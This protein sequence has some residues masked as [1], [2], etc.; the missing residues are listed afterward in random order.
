MNKIKRLILIDAY[1]TGD[2]VKLDLDGNTNLNGDNGA[3][4]TT[5]LKIVPIFYGAAPGQLVRRTG[6]I[7]SFVNYYLK[8]PFSYIIFEYV[9]EDTTQLV[10]IYRRNQ[11][12]QT[13]SYRFIQS[14][15]QKRLFFGADG[16]ADKAID[17]RDLGAHLKHQ[18]IICSGAMNGEDYK[19]VMQNNTPYSGHS[20]QK[21]QLI[22][23]YRRLYSLC[24]PGTNMHNIDLITTAILGRTPSI[25]GIKAIIKTILINREVISD[26]EIMLQTSAK[27]LQDWA[28]GVESYQ[29]FDQKIHVIKHLQN[30]KTEY[31]ATLQALDQINALAQNTEQTL[32]QDIQQQNALIAADEQSLTQL[33]AAFAHAQDAHTQQTSALTHDH[34]NHQQDADKQIQEKRDWEA[35]DML[36]LQHMVQGLPDLRAEKTA[37]ADSLV[38]LTTGASDIMQQYESLTIQQTARLQDKTQ[39]HRQ[40]LHALES[41]ANKQQSAVSEHFK[42]QRAQAFTEYEHALEQHQAAIKMIW[43]AKAEIQ[44]HLTLCQAPAA[45]QQEADALVTLMTDAHKQRADLDAR[46]HTLAQDMDTQKKALDALAHTYAHKK[47]EQQALDTEQAL[48]HQLTDS[49]GTLL[50]FLRDNCP[51]W[52]ESIGKLLPESLLLRK[53]LHPEWL[54]PEQAS[55]YGIQLDLSGLPCPRALNETQL[56]NALKTLASDITARQTELTQLS[57]QRKPLERTQMALK[58]AQQE[59]QQAQ[60]QHQRAVQQAHTEHQQLQKK[61]ALAIAEQKQ[62]LQTQL[63][64]ICQQVT[65]L[66]A[67]KQQCTRAHQAQMAS[68]NAQEHTEK[69]AIEAQTQIQQTTIHT[70]IQA[71]TEAHT[72]HL[73]TLDEEKHRALAQ[74][75]VDSG[76]VKSL[77]NALIQLDKT[78]TEAEQ[79]EQQVKNYTFWLDGRWAT[80]ALLKRKIDQ[81]SQRLT[82][83]EHTWQASK[84]DH[85]AGLERVRSSLSTHK[86]SQDQHTQAQTQ[87]SGLLQQLTDSELA[88]QPCDVT[89]SSLHTVEWLI[90]AFSQHKDSHRKQQAEGR[91]CYTSVLKIM[92]THLGSAPEQYAVRMEAEISHLPQANEQPWYY[93]AEKLSTYADSGHR[94]DKDQL[95]MYFQGHGRNITDYFAKLKDIDK[96]I[97]RIGNQVTQHIS[98]LSLDIE[99]IGDLAVSITSKLST[100]EYWPY[101]ENFSA[102]YTTWHN[103]NHDTLPNDALIEQLKNIADIIK[104]T[105]LNVSIIQHFDVAIYVTDQGKRTHA[106]TD[107]E[108]KNISSTGL[109]Y[110]IIIMIY[111]AMANMLRGHSDT[112][113]IWP[114]DELKNFSEDKVDKIM[115]FLGQY[116]IY[117]FSAFPDPDPDLFK[118]YQHKYM[119]DR[120]RQLVTY[121]QSDIDYSVHDLFEAQADETP[122][123]T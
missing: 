119:V 74:K 27:N 54:G 118:H 103:Q 42:N 59:N 9:R 102:L 7:D 94:E 1:K 31:A 81:L 4:K 109:S 62:Q 10:A 35:Q 91:K 17:S 93:A 23:E 15:Y 18:G 48:I 64:D 70:Q 16:N 110:L 111:T 82:H 73:S 108:L 114:V 28:N 56:Q 11:N 26:G 60:R 72:Q 36:R 50:G 117:I 67:Q 2:I 30:L 97:N 39:T 99:E 83:L 57:E 65:T 41:A 29:A 43:Q 46:T 100:L 55:L 40:T 84:N 47:R 38:A 3:G 77:E 95:V 68:V 86:H 21:N 14:D 79:A 96:K 106:R 61:M 92:K 87:L 122:T 33:K 80:H 22:T 25:L 105:G 71:L 24:K 13:A 76:T 37:Q 52:T 20:H 121:A 98:A 8:R 85:M 32:A 69:Q 90:Q 63:H 112:T 123:L 115:R 75:G 6:N 88:Y 107:D 19:R 58:H 53:D 78:I 120:G 89:P 45:L 101:L 5:L 104:D 12:E 51:D 116:N 49:E 34:A 44:T 113:L 66:E